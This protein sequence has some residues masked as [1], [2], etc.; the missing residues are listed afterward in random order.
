MIWAATG[1]A[2]VALLAVLL[3]DSRK[4]ATAPAATAG[5]HGSSSVANAPVG[6]AIGDRAPDFTLR[7]LHGKQ[8]RLQGFLGK[9][10]MLHFWAVD[11]TYCRAEQPDYIQAIKD[12][13]A[14]APTI[15]AVDAWGESTG[16]V[17]PYVTHTHLPGIVL[18]D[19]PHT[20][21][22]SLYKGQGTPTTVYIDKQ[23]VIR[24]T[25]IGPETHDQIMANARSIGA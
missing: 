2:L 13:G 17:A 8:V 23:G 16:Y 10:V 11:C 24:Q 19:P 20:V 4:T 21:F 18:I 22:D 15:L 1:I 6:A 5:L 12:L 3:V 7:D 14:H 9:P 25:V